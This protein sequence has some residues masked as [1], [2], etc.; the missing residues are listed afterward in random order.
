MQTLCLTTLIVFSVSSTAIGQSSNSTPDFDQ[1]TEKTYKS[2]DNI[3]LKLWTFSP[4]NH[5]KTDR[6]PAAIFFFGGGWKS[7]TPAQFEQHCRYLAS[8]GMIAITADYRVRSRHQTLA[9]RCVADAKSAIRWMRMHSDELGIDPNRILAGG[10][11]A[12]GH[13]A[14]CAATITELD[15]P[16]EDL[17]VSS[18]PNALALFNPA[19]LLAPFGKVSLDAEKLKDIAT[20]TGVEPHRISPIHNVRSGQP[21][22]IA[23]HGTADTT[24]PFETIRLF[25]TETR[26]AGNTFNLHG[27][28]GQ[29]H[30]FFNYGRGGNPGEYFLRTVHALD[31]FLIGLGYLEGDPTIV[32][33]QST[34]V[35][36]RSDLSNARK[37]IEN[38]KATVAFIGGSITE[39]NG[40]RPMIMRYLADTY[41]NTTFEFINAGISSTCSTT[42]AFRLDRDV[43]SHDPDL[44]FVEFAVNDDQDAGHAS[45]E[46]IRG[47]EGIVRQARSKNPETDIVLTHF[48]NPPML[49]MLRNGQTPTSI[50]AHERVASHYGI[51]S[52][53]LAMEVAVRIDDGSLTWKAYGGTHPK[54][55]GNRLAADLNIECLR[56]AFNLAN[57]ADSSRLPKLLDPSSYIDGR[58][59]ENQTV[60]TGAGWRHITPDWNSLPGKSRERYEKERLLCCTT[61]GSEVT[62]RFEGNTIGAFVLAGPDAGIIET[63][64]D[65]ETFRSI[66]LYHR[67]SKGLH[68]PRTVI[69]GSDLEP[70]E[71]KLVLR[72]SESSNSESTGHAARILN[73]VVNHSR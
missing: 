40:Y 8:R 9:D 26:K 37:A 30:G 27:Y 61:P 65:G 4:D 28:G 41:P 71:H 43:L 17:S 66:D 15:E 60:Q 53:N 69:L 5:Q 23:F 29:S 51:N 11:S 31:E 10:G 3:D 36:V 21:P 33:P 16:D 55:P 35:H 2:V 67:F 42:G 47:M 63:S 68:Y 24:V 20:R 72:L 59:V 70:G 18:V 6:R 14:A 38:G 25:E 46:C 19:L 13:L 50:A 64:I 1:A 57:G 39:M 32:V 45:R 73:F 44:V 34:N 56:A 48:V 52:V 12:G 62:L 22:M 54:M 49:E 7:G 58:L